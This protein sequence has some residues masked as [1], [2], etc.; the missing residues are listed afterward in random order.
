MK[1]LL[2]LIGG[3]LLSMSLSQAAI[4]VNYVS[5]SPS[6]S[7]T[8]YNYDIDIASSTTVRTGDFFVIYDFGAVI[9]SVLPAGWEIGSTLLSGPIPAFQNPNDNPALLNVEIRYT[10]ADIVG[11]AFESL[12]DLQFSLVSAESTL[13]NGT[14]NV[15]SQFLDNRGASGV[16]G[17]TRNL[18]VPATGVPEPGTMG[19]LGASLLGVGMLARRRSN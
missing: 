10:G 1:R 7:N 14:G 6:G 15:S 18:P 19:L 12:S 17:D 5:Q 13:L 9:S 4:I 16:G 2:T 3:A 11:P 8:S